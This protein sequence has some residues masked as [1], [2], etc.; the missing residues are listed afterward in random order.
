MLTLNIKVIYSD[1]YNIEESISRGPVIN[2]DQIY[3][4]TLL[5]YIYTD[6]NRK[7]FFM[8]LNGTIDHFVNENTELNIYVMYV[9]ISCLFIIF[10]PLIEY[11]WL[12]WGKIKVIDFYPVF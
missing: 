9:S 11:S 8:D 4:F 12:P 10:S 3:G 7:Y 5:Y 2:L 1:L 6:K